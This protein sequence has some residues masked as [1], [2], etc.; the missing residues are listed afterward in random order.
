M[1]AEIN[2]VQCEAGFAVDVDL[3]KLDFIYRD[4]GHSETTL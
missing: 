2:L 1:N 3:I 4:E